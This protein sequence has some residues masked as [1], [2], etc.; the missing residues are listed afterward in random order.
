[1][2]AN[3]TMEIIKANDDSNINLNNCNRTDIADEHDNA[4][5]SFCETSHTNWNENNKVGYLEEQYEILH[6]SVIALTSH[7]SQVQLRIHQI[8]E[9]PDEEKKHLLKNLEEFAFKGIPNVYTNCSLNHLLVTTNDDDNMV[10][11]KHQ[12]QI[13]VI[14]EMKKQLEA[15]ESHIYNNKDE[16]D[17]PE[18]FVDVFRERQNNIINQVEKK[19]N[20]S[21]K[22]SKNMSVEELKEEVDNAIQ[23][24]VNPMKATEHL[25]DQ[26]KTQ[27]A[28]LER[29]IQ[30][31]QTGKIKLKTPG[32]KVTKISVSKDK[33]FERKSRDV[34]TVGAVRRLTAIIQMFIGTQISCTQRHF[35]MNTLKKSMKINHWG[36]YRANL[37]L[38]VAEL[39]EMLA[40]PEI[41]VDSDYMSDS[42]GAIAAMECNGKIAL[43]VR[44]R[45]APAIQ[46]LIQHGLM[47]VGQS[48]SVVPFV[49]CL[50]PKMNN[51]KSTM[52]AWELILKYYE[53]KNG[54][55]F[56]S[57]PARKLSQSFNLDIEGCKS[58]VSYKQCLLSIIGNIIT[59]HSRYK[60]SYGSCFKAFVCAGLNSKMFVSWLKFIF[61]CQ[62]LVELYY[63]PWSYVAQTGFD[64]A[65]RS[66]EKLNQYN[67]DLPADLAI[68]Q[69]Q[70]IKD[71][72]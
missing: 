48:T 17:L 70:N 43:T 5:Y 11:K 35:K 4:L 37:E 46:H 55:Y 23:K 57:T 30:Y 38:V 14:K 66:L 42:E 9:S 15:L 41:H 61:K 19:L 12:V 32:D 68:R 27:I 6:S 69:L 21:I 54:D 29:F 2:S 58:S 36:D 56:N 28:D 18:S 62:P 13:E 59:S 3:L 10:E 39:L 8:I 51:S 45:L 63:Q 20:L 24:L 64:D 67:F 7:F 65:L 49:D 52:H 40:L 71:A 26:L 1:M 53:I 33:S 47:V 50:H 44:N 22:N 34:K 16:F 72:F 31:L 25:V 60:R